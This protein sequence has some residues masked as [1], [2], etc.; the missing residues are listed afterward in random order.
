GGMPGDG[1]VFWGEGGPTGS[2]MERSAGLHPDEGRD[3][4]G[5]VARGGSTGT[6]CGAG[7]GPGREPTGAPVSSGGRAMT[8]LFRLSSEGRGARRGVG[9][10]LVGVVVT[11]GAARVGRRLCTSSWVMRAPVTGP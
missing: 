11:G 2:A 5:A 8:S 7:R 3:G 6:G 9:G 1:L 4:S 10:E